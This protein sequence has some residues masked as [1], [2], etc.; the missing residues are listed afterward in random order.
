ME[1]SLYSKLWEMSINDRPEYVSAF[2]S[3]D[4]RNRVC[5]YH[6]D[7]YI[8]LTLNSIHVTMLGGG[9]FPGN[10]FNKHNILNKTFAKQVFQKYQ[11]LQDDPT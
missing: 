6:I 4:G 1:E 5:I 3:P 8:E 2:T 10:Y 9:T 7:F 11:H